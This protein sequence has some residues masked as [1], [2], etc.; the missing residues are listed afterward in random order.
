M[1]SSDWLSATFEVERRH[2]CPPYPPPTP[3]PMFPVE[4]KERR[5]EEVVV[6]VVAMV[7]RSFMVI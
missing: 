5:E 1:L 4:A 3:R 2:A 7:S 6:V